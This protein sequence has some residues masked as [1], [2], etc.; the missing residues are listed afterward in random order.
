MGDID[1][2]GLRL[3]FS[4]REFVDLLI[5]R[6]VDAVELTTHLGW[7]SRERLEALSTRLDI[8]YMLRA[9]HSKSP[10]WNRLMVTVKGWRKRMAQ[11]DGAKH[12]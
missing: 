8:L 11:K 4:D 1:E 2:S 3:P 12:G 7:R 5:C 10:H 9:K 6:F